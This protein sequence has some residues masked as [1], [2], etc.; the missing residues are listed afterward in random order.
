[1][2]EVFDA[3]KNL[4]VFGTTYLDVLQAKRVF[5]AVFFVSALAKILPGGLMRTWWPKIPHWI[6]LVDVNF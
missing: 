4:S 6:W 2:N 1:M 5:T 3:L